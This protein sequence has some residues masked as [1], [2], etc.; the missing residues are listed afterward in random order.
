MLKGKIRTITIIS[1]Q[2]S[3][4]LSMFYI[5]HKFSSELWSVYVKK[6]C[7]KILIILITGHFISFVE[8]AFCI[9]EEVSNRNFRCFSANF[10][11]YHCIA[12]GYRCVH[13]FRVFIYLS[14]LYYNM[15]CICNFRSD[16]F[17]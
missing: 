4:T 14:I 13:S 17:P 2:F 10:I 6:S 5:L 11:R 8:K 7:N 16:Y 15:I 12:Y 3:L 1:H 9:K